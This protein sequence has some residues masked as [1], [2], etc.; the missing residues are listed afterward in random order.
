MFKK[1]LIIFMP[2]IDIGGVEK[3][4]Y[5]ISNYL[6]N[7]VKDLRICTFSKNKKRK[8]NKNIKFITS[9]SKINK[10]TNNRLKYIFCLFL[11]FKFLVKNRDSVVFAFQGNIYCIL[12]CKFLGIQVIVRT[13][14]SPSGWDHNSIKKRI[15]K[16]IISKADAV[17]SNSYNFKKQMEEQFDI[18]VKCIFNPLNRKEISIKSKSGKKINFFNN[19]KYLKILNIGRLTDQKDQIVMIKALELLKR[20]NIKYRSIIIGDG[21]EENNLKNYIIKNNLTK[22]IKIRQSLENPYKV[23]KQADLFILSSKFEG[24]P[25]VLLEAALLKKFIISSDC[26]TGPSEILQNGKGGLL[27]K[28]GDYN[29]LKNKIISYINN[30]KKFQKKINFCFKN[31]DRFDLNKNLDAYNK[32]IQRFLTN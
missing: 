31:L 21:E 1:K 16:K 13:N 15:Y 28:V 4:L 30:K 6:A 8:F 11:L 10:K 20:K 32:L 3:N 2:Y 17:I 25:N 9:N 19:K 5:I 14:T 29:D 27:F 26:S 18:K 23:I 22:D 7:K 12:L 24:L